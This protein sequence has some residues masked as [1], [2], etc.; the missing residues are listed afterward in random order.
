M[1]FRW[2]ASAPQASL[3]RKH[4][5]TVGTEDPQEPT[6]PEAS[7]QPLHLDSCRGRSVSSPVDEGGENQ[8]HKMDC[9]KTEVQSLRKAE[10]AAPR[11]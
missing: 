6:T 2:S 8:F 1:D 5:D 7:L 4:K 3:S 10:K 11:I 9:G